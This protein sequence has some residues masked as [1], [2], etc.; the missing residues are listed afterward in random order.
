MKEG[1]EANGGLAGT[2]IAIVEPNL[3]T[4]KNV[5]QLKGISTYTNFEYEGDG[6]MRVYQAY[7]VGTGKLIN[8]KGSEY[9][10]P[11]DPFVGE[12]KDFKVTDN[13][14]DTTFKQRHRNVSLARLCPHPRCSG[15]ILDG[16]EASHEHQLDQ[17]PEEDLLGLDMYKQQWGEEILGEGSSL[18]GK[19]VYEVTGNGGVLDLVQILLI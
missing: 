10:V 2:M 1:I 4:R 6:K 17:L 12:G 14:E 7:A 15:V 9:F 13:S 18:R 19:S 16:E 3:R 11:L 5:A 8:I